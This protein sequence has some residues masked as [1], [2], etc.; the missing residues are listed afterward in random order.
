MLLS[1][2]ERLFCWPTSCH[3]ISAGWTYTDGSVHHALDTKSRDDTGQF[4]A[5]PVVAAERATVD[6]VQTWDGV[7]K[8]GNQSYG[9]CVRLRHDN[10][11]GKSLQSLYAHLS[12]ITVQS[13]QT[14]EEGQ[15]IGYTG[16]TGN[17]TGPHLHF[18]VRLGGIRVNPLNWLDNDFTCASDTV[19]KHLGQYKSVV[20]P[21]TETKKL[22]LLFV[23][24]ASDAVLQKAQDAGLDVR[25]CT[26]YL[27]GP[28][29]DGDAMAIWQLAETDGC[30]YF[31]S[32]TEV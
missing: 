8:T 10:Y 12:K 14:V 11:N 22:Q 17:V 29:S 21:D 7:T 6:W 32:T 28:A 26:G 16:S 2:G 23:A 3:V 20:R 18:E 13:G 1:N 31:A 19:R 24:E 9:N 15:I 4:I 5:L 25:S 30:P 27:I